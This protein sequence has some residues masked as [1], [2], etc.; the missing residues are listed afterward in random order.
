MK[1]TVIM[2]VLVAS[3]SGCSESPAPQQNAA[4]TNV[5]PTP[6]Q[7]I[8][9]PEM[10]GATLL[11]LEQFTG[12]PRNVSPDG[13]ERTYKVGACE[14]TAYVGEGENKSVSALRFVVA[15]GC[16][17][18]VGKF[19]DSS[20]G[21]SGAML[22]QLSFGKFEEMV[23][24]TTRYY[25]DCLTLCGNAADPTV[26]AHWE[27][28]RSADFLEMM[29]EVKLVDDAS[30]QA[31]DQ[32]KAAMEAKEGE[33]WV[34]DTGFNCD[35]VKYNDVARKGFAA[36]K[37]EAI[38]IGRG[39]P[40]PKCAQATAPAI[41]ATMNPEQLVVPKPA[42]ECDYDYDNTLKQSG[43]VVK[44]NLVHGPE[45]TDFAGYGC[46]YRITPPPGTPLQKGATVQYRIAYEGG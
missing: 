1:K 11:Y 16:D 4:L 46:P 14:I 20:P 38:T 5:A 23:G 37:P 42:S 24:G 21:A 6:M 8:F 29:V 2:L 10:I 15:P 7:Q 3:M 39:L 36:V 19:L 17:G 27:G 32:W 44:K 22:S 34:V 9:Q 26:Y 41:H 31:A 30:L 43:L 13:M 12:P 33:D 35:P 40:V 28:P 25:A 45:D 18:D